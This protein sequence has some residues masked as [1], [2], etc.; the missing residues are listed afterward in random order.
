[1]KTRSR[2]H[3]ILLR[4]L[5]TGSELSSFRLHHIT[6]GAK[7]LKRA[8]AFYTEVLGAKAE[9]LNGAPSFAARLGEVRIAIFQSTGKAAAA[10]IERSPLGFRRNPPGL[11]RIVLEVDDLEQTSASLRS[12]GVEIDFDGFHEEGR[13]ARFQDPEGNVIGLIEST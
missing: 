9:P 1:M 3:I 6:L 13:F 11:D 7:D 4:F 5:R 8:H 2:Q 12:R 10:S